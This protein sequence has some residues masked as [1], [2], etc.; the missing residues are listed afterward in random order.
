MAVTSGMKHTVGPQV[1]GTSGQI[2]C[3]LGHTPLRNFWVFKEID[4]N[5]GLVDI[6]AP[7][8]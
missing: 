5:H 7:K 8:F 3:L 1:A 6:N 2:P 4:F